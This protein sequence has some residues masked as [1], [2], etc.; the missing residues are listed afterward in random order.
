[1]APEII[2]GQ[3]YTEKSD[4]Y[5]FAIV[6]WEMVSMQLPFYGMDPTAAAN[7]VLQ[8][9]LRPH[10]PQFCPQPVAVLISSCWNQEPTLRPS[11]KQIGELIKRIP[12]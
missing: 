1:M 6:L 11:F 4:V 7:Q 3:P 5:S 12:G 9:G 2:A 8:G 10:I